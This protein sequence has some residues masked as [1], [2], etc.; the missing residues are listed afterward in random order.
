[1]I[2]GNGGQ[3]MEITTGQ[4]AQSMKWS[5]IW[6]LAILR[7]TI[8]SFTR[9]IDDPKASTIWGIVWMAIAT[10]IGWLVG[11]QRTVLSG[12]AGNLFGPQA[13]GNFQIIGAIAF[14]I[15][16]VI[17]LLITAAISHGLAR[18]FTGKGSY[19]QLV[20]CWGVMLLPFVVLPWLVMFIPSLIF[21]MRLTLLS[22]VGRIY[23]IAYLVIWIVIYLY[24][25]Y[26]QVVAYSAVEKFSIW[27][28]LG[29]LAL[30][31]ILIG[32]AGSC[33]S[34]GVKELLAKY[35]QMF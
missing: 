32:I 19:R 35:A 25:F 18:L 11:P 16:G 10:L 8:N 14:P 29:I 31:A 23:S 21:S 1:M 3:G 27:K 5:E 12:Y 20:F 24:L 6:R 33:L 15:L 30:Q 2:V 17:G 28:G 13:M 26:A 7:P 22:A 4:A 9:I 34:A